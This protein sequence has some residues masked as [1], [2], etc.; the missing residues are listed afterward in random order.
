MSQALRKLVGAVRQNNAALLFT[1]QLRQKT[2]VL[3]GNPEIPTG[4]MALRFY[5]SVGIHL[6]RTQALKS[7]GEVIGSRIKATIKKN[8]VASPFRSAEF[9]IRYE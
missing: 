4:E 3:F 8:K 5:A 1:N 9:D 7:N 2:G 6:C